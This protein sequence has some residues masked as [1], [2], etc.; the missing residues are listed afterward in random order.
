[1]N[2]TIVGDV[3]MIFLELQIVQGTSMFRFFNVL[4]TRKEQV[5]VLKKI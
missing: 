5:V 4:N 1:M 2:Q 3:R